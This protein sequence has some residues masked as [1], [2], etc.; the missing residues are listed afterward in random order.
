MAKKK[1]ADELS[2][3]L[4]KVVLKHRQR[5]GWSQNELAN[6]T[7]FHRTYIADVEQGTRNLAVRNLSRLAQI[8]GVQSSRLLKEAEKL[9]GQKS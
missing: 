5:L 1:Y 2:A 7:S 9:V 8:F 6:A 4:S 3:A